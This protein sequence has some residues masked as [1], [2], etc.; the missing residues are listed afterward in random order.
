MDARDSR[1]GDKTDESGQKSQ[2]SNYKINEPWGYHVQ[3]GN[4]S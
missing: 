2:T 4:S 1:E 3:H